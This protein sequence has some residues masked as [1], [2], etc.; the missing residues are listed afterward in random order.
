MPT[1]FFPGYNPFAPGQPWHT[2]L[3]EPGIDYVGN[4]TYRGHVLNEAGAERNASA[5]GE[6][7]V[8]LEDNIVT[9]VDEYTAPADGE[10]SF[11]GTPL[12]PRFFNNPSARWY[13]HGQTER[14]QATFPFQPLQGLAS[15][16]R[17]RFTALAL[18]ANA[19]RPHE[20]RHVGNQ[21]YFDNI[22]IPVADISGDADAIG[23]ADLLTLE[24]FSPPA[25]LYKI[26]FVGQ[27]DSY[28]SGT[29]V[30]LI[31]AMEDTDDV[32]LA[33]GTIV[34]AGMGDRDL[35]PTFNYGGEF[36][37]E[38]DELE[39]NDGDQ[40]RWI[41]NGLSGARTLRG[42]MRLERTG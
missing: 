21:N 25:G 18:P 14:V 33:S 15:R 3:V 6:V 39:V 20:V 2:A 19:Y 26:K 31:L 10:T 8:L 12:I 37:A 11:L 38:E 29:S 34:N 24:F 17:V 35:T 27:M 32:S 42:Y 1:G 40:F 9:F 30:G 22:F 36:F 28:E 5:A 7:Y 4:F 23:H 16:S 13:L 41:L